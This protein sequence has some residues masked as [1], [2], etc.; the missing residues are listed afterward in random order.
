MFS[1][2]SSFVLYKTAFHV[3]IFRFDR[4]RANLGFVKAIEESK[5]TGERIRLTYTSDFDEQGRLRVVFLFFQ[6]LNSYKSNGFYAPLSAR[7]GVRKSS[8]SIVSIQSMMVVFVL[9]FD[10]A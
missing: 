8:M 7:P 1:V 3:S 5:K 10:G 6:T 9:L 4:D 2:L